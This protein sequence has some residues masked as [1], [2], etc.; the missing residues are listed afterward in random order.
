MQ[1]VH[2]PATIPSAANDHHRTTMI[3][4]NSLRHTCWL[5]SFEQQHADHASETRRQR[6]TAMRNTSANTRGTLCDLGP[7]SSPVRQGCF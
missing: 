1:S 3:G 5:G 7:P 2:R 4:Y 6:A